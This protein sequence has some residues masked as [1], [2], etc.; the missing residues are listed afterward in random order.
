[1]QAGTEA[2]RE[3]VT[4]FVKAWT[5]NDVDT[6]IELLAADAHWD[7]PPSIGAVFDGPQAIAH[8]LSGGAAGK[9]VKV[10]T[11]RRTVLR[12]IVDGDFA[13]VLVRLSATAHTGVEYVNDYA[14]HYELADGRVR[15]IV[16][17]A[18]TLFAARLGFLPF[19]VPSA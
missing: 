7:T 3:V 5:T 2:T 8:Q 10:E 1:M 17:Y 12:I 15:R 11:V 19:E 4:R 6:V 14:W 9:Y 16:E 18:D 13:M